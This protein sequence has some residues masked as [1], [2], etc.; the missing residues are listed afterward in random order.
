MVYNR[1][2]EIVRRIAWWPLLL[3]ATLIIPAAASGDESS[4]EE[5]LKEKNLRK[6]GTVYALADESKLSQMMSQTA[7]LKRL[8]LD[9]GKA[10]VNAERLL[11]AKKQTLAQMKLKHVELSTALTNVRTV[12]DNNRLVGMLNSLA[13]QIDVGSQDQAAENNLKQARSKANEAREAF[14]Q[15]VIDMRSLFDSVQ[16]RY[17]LL[18][19]DPA[20]IQA[21]KDLNK[22]SEKEITLGP[23]KSVG[24]FDRQLSKIEETVLSEEIV[25]RIGNGNLL[26]VSA[27]FDGKETIEIA[28]DT[29][30]SSIVLSWDLAEQL[31]LKPGPDSRRAIFV[32][33]DGR[34]TEGRI[35]TAKSVRVGKFTVE[36]VECAV[37]GPENTNVE[38]LLGQSFL[39]NFIYKI[40]SGRGVI[41]ITRIED[42]ATSRSRASRTNDR[43]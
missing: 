7:K 20:V 24:S 39:E 29:G 17:E 5:I 33:A 16:D 8:A 13:G 18:K 2:F 38:P 34:Q 42:G 9:A 28:V 21:L 12:E 31:G 4:A 1:Q 10:L 26:Y 15:H 37:L 36:D 27:V 25:A 14:A 35:V 30:A 23:S 11:A 3:L 43:D 32:M 22:T 41:S 40:D 6:V 19:V